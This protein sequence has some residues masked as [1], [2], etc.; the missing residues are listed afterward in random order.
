M[1]LPTSARKFE[2]S[3][4]AGQSPRLQE[5]VQD[6]PQT[7]EEFLATGSAALEVFKDALIEDLPRPLRAQVQSQVREIV[8][9]G[10]AAATCCRRQDPFGDTSGHGGALQ[11]AV[12]GSES[13]GIFEVLTDPACLVVLVSKLLVDLLEEPPQLGTNLRLPQRFAKPVVRLAEDVLAHVREE[14]LVAVENGCTR[15]LFSDG[16]ADRAGE[17]LDHGRR[18][19]ES[20]L[21]I[22]EDATDLNSVLRVD[23][24][25]P[26]HDRLGADETGEVNMAALFAGSVDM[27]CIAARGLQRRA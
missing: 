20:L 9:E 27:E 15:P 10:P 2:F 3:S 26:E 5:N 17:I 18:L 1:S 19:G 21:D 25:T 22:P 16:V 6:S 13:V 11:R 7:I 14:V 4:D 8:G 12:F 23:S 24:V